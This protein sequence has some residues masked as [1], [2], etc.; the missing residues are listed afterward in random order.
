MPLPPPANAGNA[1]MQTLVKEKESKTNSIANLTKTNPG[2]H[3]TEKVKIS[4]LPQLVRK[5]SSKL[6]K[7]PKY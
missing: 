3:E 6:T 2:T 5:K 1:V 7:A 4:T